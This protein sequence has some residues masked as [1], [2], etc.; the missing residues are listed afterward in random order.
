MISRL[1]LT[2]IALLLLPACAADAPPT[3]YRLSSGEV[4]RCR[5]SRWTYCG[6]ELGACEGGSRYQCQT[7]FE[8]MP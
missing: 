1:L 4:V 7:N 5:F 6:F 2:T 3:A 8:V